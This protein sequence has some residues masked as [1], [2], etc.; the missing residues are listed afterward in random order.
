[1]YLCILLNFVNPFCTAHRSSV[2]KCANFTY[3]THIGP[4]INALK[5][6]RCRITGT[7]FSSMFQY[8]NIGSFDVKKSTDFCN[9]WNKWISTLYQLTFAALIAD[10]SFNSEHDNQITSISDIGTPNMPSMFQYWNIGIT[11]TKNTI[12][13]KW[14]PTL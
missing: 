5:F 4:N 8:W 14:Q 6:V 1:M 7:Y 12:L 3:M 2:Q 9:I 11:G 13:N 10:I